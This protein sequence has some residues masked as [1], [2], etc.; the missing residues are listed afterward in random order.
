MYPAPNITNYITHPYANNF[1]L[2]HQFFFFIR[3]T[4][5]LRCALHTRYYLKRMFFCIPLFF[6]MYF[7][8]FHEYFVISLRIVCFILFTILFSLHMVVPL[9]IQTA[10]IMFIRAILYVTFVF[11]REC[12][13]CYL[14]YVY[15]FCYACALIFALLCLCLCVYV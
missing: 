8:S 11:T 12:A 7:C 14:I 15:I 3:F 5:A 1:I 4:T 2:Y 10:C 9:D 6:K 13:S